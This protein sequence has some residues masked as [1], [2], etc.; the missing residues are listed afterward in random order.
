MCFAGFLKLQIKLVS[1]FQLVQLNL[2]PLILPVSALL[3]TRPPSG[4]ILQDEHPS[5]C[6]WFSFG[7]FCPGLTSNPRKPLRSRTLGQAACMLKDRERFLQQLLACSPSLCS[8]CCPSTQKPFPFPA[9]PLLKGRSSPA[10]LFPGSCCAGISW[11]E[12][13]V[14]LHMF[15]VLVSLPLLHMQLSLPAS[16]PPF[17]RCLFLPAPAK[18]TRGEVIFAAS[19]IG[20]ERAVRSAVTFSV[21]SRRWLGFLKPCP[22]GSARCS[23]SCSLQLSPS[24]PSSSQSPLP[25]NPICREIMGFECFSPAPSV[26]VVPALLAEPSLCRALHFSGFACS[27]K[28]LTV[29][30]ISSGPATI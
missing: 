2:N 14:A 13:H 16:V 24:C 28:Q 21:G 27:K 3:V 10:S 12:S 30:K 7:S 25:C 8:A 5:L 11:K 26:W 17:H 29:V 20:H 4:I 19:Q 23:F 6:C 18:E 1:V 22:P 9:T 15:A